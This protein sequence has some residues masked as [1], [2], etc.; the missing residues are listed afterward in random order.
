MGALPLTSVGNIV[1]CI[2][3][4]VFSEKVASIIQQTGEGVK[5]V[6]VNST[7]NIRSSAII[8][9][10]WNIQVILCKN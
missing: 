4:I 6:Y 7:V 8:R 9:L 10:I 1:S 2:C 5:L 3:I